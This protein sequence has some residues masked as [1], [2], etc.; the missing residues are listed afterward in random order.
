MPRIQEYRQQ[1]RAPGAVNFKQASG[2]SGLGESLQA[3][4]QAV[5]NISDTYDNYQK[6]QAQHNASQ[7]TAQYALED[8]KY[9]TEVTDSYNPN[10]YKKPEGKP[11]NWEF[12]D[13]IQEK[14]ESN[15]QERLAKIDNRYERDALEERLTTTNAKLVMEARVK[16]K[17]TEAKYVKQN[18]QD[19]QNLYANMVRSNPNRLEDAKAMMEDYYN[20]LPSQYNGIKDQLKTQSTQVLYDS[21][22][23]GRVSSLSTKT[24]PS[25]GEINSLIAQMK[26]EKGQWQGNVSKEK[27][28]QSITKLES[29][30]KTATAAYE[31]QSKMDF[32]QEMDRIVR[33]GID[34]KSYQEKYTV[35]Y[36]NKSSFTPKEKE[37]MLALREQALTK[38]IAK[39]ETQNMTFQEAAN[40]YT[41]ADLRKDANSD[42]NNFYKYKAKYDSIQ[43]VL[44]QSQK[45]FKEDP[46]G[47]T[48]GVKPEFDDMVGNFEAKWAMNQVSPEEVQSYVLTTSEAQ[49]K[50]D[51]YA[52]P[53]I[54]TKDMSN[55][56]KAVLE[57]T[58][59]PGAA[60]Q[61][62][63]QESQKWGKNWK[64][65]LRDLSKDK[66]FNPT[67]EVASG[68][69]DDPMKRGF[70]ES[71]FKAAKLSSTELDTLY[72]AKI[73]DNELKQQVKTS[74]NQFL[75]S[76]KFTTDYDDISL[77]YLEGA[78]NITKYY[79]GDKSPQDVTNLL[80]ND[81]YD[82]VDLKSNVVRVPKNLGIPTSKITNSLPNV[83][84]K[85]LNKP[86][87][88]F[89]PPS[90][91][92]GLKEEDKARMYANR[93]WSNGGFVN[94]GDEGVRLVDGE[95]NQIWG[96]ESESGG[97]KN[98]RP[99][100][101]NWKE[102]N[103]ISAGV[104]NR[105][106]S[107]IYSGG[108]K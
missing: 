53:R 14:L 72:G 61:A 5:N 87:S 104:F 94:D 10:T 96:V 41:E 101:F 8:D 1:T 30:K 24:N 73:N 48:R 46:I 17:A 22:L 82:F 59:N 60:Y 47:Y 78:T 97:R 2:I 93:I 69:I 19:T 29:M 52:Q 6:Q 99:I 45:Q 84:E 36:I 106:S 105:P 98:Y 64:M 63:L 27:F 71:A 81:K 56:L 90:L 77:K 39:F 3:V 67:M 65:A 88:I 50:V 31:T 37:K 51:A 32:E 76:Q 55:G 43:D 74:L 83:V 108:S 80:V 54:V 9:I 25:I 103:T 26:N 62:V 18:A 57:D 79:K 11:D 95:G 92:K 66:V 58:T 34:P 16:Q 35:D 20:T 28:D 49:K 21:A 23:D 38:G 44:K 4:G 91:Y 13:D 70:V 15:K 75:K 42:P 12:A 33:V 100:K 40:F 102:L 68:V 85:I 89:V 107:N 7:K 86:D